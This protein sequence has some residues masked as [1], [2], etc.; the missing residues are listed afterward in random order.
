MSTN[1]PKKS[2]YLRYLIYLL[3]IF[4]IVAGY[5]AITL[6]TGEPSP[7]TIVTGS[8]M[9]PTIIPGS[10][11]MI[12]KVPFD[13]LKK[14]EIIVFVPPVAQSGKC[15]SSPPRVLTQ[16]AGIIPCFVIHRIIE[17]TTGPNGERMIMTKGDNN[18]GPIQNIDYWITQS[19]YIGMVIYQ[20]PIAGY[21]TQPP[22]NFYLGSVLVALFAI[23]ILWEASGS[24]KSKEKSTE[25]VS[26]PAKML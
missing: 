26:S 18:P 17:I 12:D 15:D 5:F 11:A 23:E 10:I 2:N 24:K 4:L 6:A 22:Y 1:H 25:K 7:F 21:V 20:L 19:M 16:D 9:N 14:G 8:S 13:Q 3:P